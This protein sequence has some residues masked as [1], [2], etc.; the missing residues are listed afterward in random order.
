MS[1]HDNEG[2]QKSGAGPLAAV[3]IVIILVAFGYW[4]VNAFLASDT[5]TGG[6]DIEIEI[7]QDDSSGD[8]S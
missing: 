4:A 1:E 2:S 7:P 5:G 3:I 6:I 8:G